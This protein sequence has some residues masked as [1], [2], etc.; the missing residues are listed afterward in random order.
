MQNNNQ[1]E[2]N[3]NDKDKLKFDNSISFCNETQKSLNEVKK[4]NK[5]LKFIKSFGIV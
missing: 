4:S 2:E 3:L 5:F 1:E